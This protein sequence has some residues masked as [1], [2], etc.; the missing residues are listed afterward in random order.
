MRRLLNPMASHPL[1]K[2]FQPPWVGLI[3]GFLH[4]DLWART[5][6]AAEEGYLVVHRRAPFTLQ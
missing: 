4:Y 3:L 1:P 6:S 5:A 2:W